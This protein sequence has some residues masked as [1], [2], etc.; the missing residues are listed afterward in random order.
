MGFFTLE[1][2]RRVG[3]TG[4]VIA[5]DIQ[6]QMLAGLRRRAERAGLLDRLDLRLATSDSL[7]VADLIGKA[8]FA[9][10]FAV[11]HE[12]PAAA[13]FFR[14][15]AGALKPEGCVLLAE[16]RGHVTAAA[17]AAQL[18]AAKQAGLQIAARPTIRRSRAAVLTK[19]QDS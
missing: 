2:A 5:M 13:P 10:A 8:D 6:P 4:W 14:E 7:G 9:L 19:I 12:L 18:H 1:L 3:A 11:V 16:P 15:I 17:F